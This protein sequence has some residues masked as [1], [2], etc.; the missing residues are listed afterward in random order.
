MV[1]F[2]RRD[3]DAA[4]PD[5]NLGS[6]PTPRRGNLSHFLPASDLEALP[7]AT[8]EIADTYL[9]ELSR[10]G[11]LPKDDRTML[12]IPARNEEDRMA[13]ALESARQF[14]GSREVVI[15]LNNKDSGT[16]PARIFSMDADTVL[17][18]GDLD[19]MEA[20][21]NSQG[22]CALAG[23]FAFGVP[24]GARLAPHNQAMNLTMHRPGRWFNGA[25]R[26]LR[27]HQFSSW[28]SGHC[29]TYSRHPHR[30][31]GLRQPS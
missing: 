22:L 5:Q 18:Q 19:R 1:N 27:N 9:S 8:F 14:G 10:L 25:L 24:E 15:S 17:G 6:R 12:M 29:Q 21:M 3:S 26:S 30:R 4:Q 20:K 28:S 31:R 2:H 7:E 23:K 13:K 11:D 16:L